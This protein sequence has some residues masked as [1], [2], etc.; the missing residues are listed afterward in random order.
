M[1]FGAKKSG[2]SFKSKPRP[3]ILAASNG[4]HD[5]EY[6]VVWDDRAKLWNVERDGDS[7]GLSARQQGAAVDL[8]IQEAQQGNE[9]RLDVI[10]C[11]QQD[12]G[13]FTTV[14]AP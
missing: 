13:T 10:V 1:A 9:K 2:S 5:H 8:A 3:R 12:D 4:R 11:V 6:H 7:T 14:W